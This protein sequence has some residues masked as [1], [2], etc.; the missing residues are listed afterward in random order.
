LPDSQS[1]IGT[2]TVTDNEELTDQQREEQEYGI[3]SSIVVPKKQEKKKKSTILKSPTIKSPLR[4]TISTDRK[5]RIIDQSESSVRGLMEEPSSALTNFN[6]RISAVESSSKVRSPKF[7]ELLEQIEIPLD[8][9][10]NM[11]PRN[12]RKNKD[13]KDEKDS[14]IS[15]GY[16]GSPISN[17]VE[18]QSDGSPPAS[19]QRI[20]I[21]L[22]KVPL[23]SKNLLTTIKRKNVYKN[24]VIKINKLN[25]ILE[26]K[27]S[28]K[29]DSPMSRERKKTIDGFNSL[30]DSIE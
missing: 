12:S 6:L 2:V 11:P 23:F 25:P 14:H 5:E 17:L 13:N 3:R 10:R 16:N 24:Q 1:G 9:E 20:H 7:E 18:Q 15:F 27:E 4:V 29:G 21:S 22:K 30:T 8:S 28:A 26:T 19:P